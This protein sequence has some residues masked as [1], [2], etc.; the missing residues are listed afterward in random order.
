MRAAIPFPDVSPDIVSFTIFGMEIALR[1]YAMAYIGSILLG[2][3]I[4]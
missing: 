2:W 1:W 4:V 3:W